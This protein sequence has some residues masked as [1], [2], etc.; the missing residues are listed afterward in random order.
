MRG[1]ALPGFGDD[2]GVE[3]A[4]DLEGAVGGAGV[5]D[6]DLVGELNAQESAGEVSLFVERDDGDGEQWRVR[7]RCSL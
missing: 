5:E 2:G 1:K 6:D 7:Q 4:G 3:G